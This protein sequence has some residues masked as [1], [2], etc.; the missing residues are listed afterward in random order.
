MKVF[1]NKASKRV[2]VTEQ[3]LRGCLDEAIKNFNK[4]DA[5]SL[6]QPRKEQNGNYVGEKD[7]GWGGATERSISHR[8]AVCHPSGGYIHNRRR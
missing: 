5:A 2:T 4:N 3:M 8:L 7:Q 6:L 1:Y